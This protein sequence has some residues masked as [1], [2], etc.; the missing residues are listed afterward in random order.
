MVDGRILRP[1]IKTAEPENF[2]QGTVNPP[3]TRSLQEALYVFAVPSGITPSPLLF[4]RVSVIRPLDSKTLLTA[5][6]VSRRLILIPSLRP[7]PGR[8]HL[9][10]P[11]DGYANLRM[12]TS[13]GA[14][15][16]R[17]RFATILPIVAKGLNALP[18]PD[19]LVN[20]HTESFAG[21]YFE[22]C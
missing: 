1:E 5:C 17:A 20:W 18:P 15:N 7:G 9:I 11:H 4:P 6:E 10:L 8:Y 14:K 2:S 21:N 12:C 16:K 3:P 13:L 22:F 19:L